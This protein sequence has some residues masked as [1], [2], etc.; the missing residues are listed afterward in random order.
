MMA[1]QAEIDRDAFWASGSNSF[2][3]W[4]SVEDDAPVRGAFVDLSRNER[5]VLDSVYWPVTTLKEDGLFWRT[6][7]PPN[8]LGNLS[9]SASSEPR[10]PID[11]DFWYVVL[12]EPQQEVTTVWRLHEQGRELYVP[13]IRRRV[14]T[15]RV[16]PERAEGHAPDSQADVPGLRHDPQNRHQGHQRY[17]RGPRRSPVAAR[18][19]LS[20]RAAT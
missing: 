3:D 8:F 17:S 9:N 11:E 1:S 7:T 2:R 12:V 10:P 5:D 16:G 6:G 15:G 20:H 18:P 4:R 14:K 19:G 13:I